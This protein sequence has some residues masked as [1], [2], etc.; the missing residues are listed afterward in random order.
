M[1]R[2][3]ILGGWNDRYVTELKNGRLAMIGIASFAANYFLP[4]SVTQIC[5]RRDFS[6]LQTTHISHN[7]PLSFQ[8]QQGS[9]PGLS[10]GF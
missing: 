5:L 3:R 2:K 1:S 10:E 6:L 4:V 9:V 8:K 7:I